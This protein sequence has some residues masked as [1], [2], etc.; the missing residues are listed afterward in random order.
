MGERVFLI[1]NI[2]YDFEFIEKLIK[3]IDSGSKFIP[4][5]YLNEFSIF[6]SMLISIDKEIINFNKK[7]H[8]KLLSL[9][10]SRSNE[11]LDDYCL[12]DKDEVSIDLTVEENLLDM[13]S[14]LDILKTNNKKRNLRTPLYD[15]S[16]L[17][18]LE[19]I[20]NFNELKIENKLNI[21]LEELNVLK[22]FKRHKPF[23][24]VELDKNIGSAIISNDL[25]F[26][27]GMKC[28][29]NSDT[30]EKIAY[31]PIGEIKNKIGRELFIIYENK[32]ISKKLY[33]KLFDDDF[34]Y[35]LGKFRYLP[36]IH[37]N[38]FSIRP[39]INYKDNPTSNLCILMDL[40]LRPFVYKMESYIK[41]SQNLIQKCEN[42][43]IE[44]S[45][46][47][48]YSCDFESLYTNID[49]NECLNL[50]S[51]FI[52]DKLCDE[53]IKIKGFHTILKLILENNYFSFE[54]NFYFHQKVGI[55]MGSRCGPSIANIFVYI[56][57]K[58][59]LNIYKP[60]LF[61]RFIDDIL[62]IVKERELVR[63]LQN[64]FGNLKLNICSSDIVNF[65]D[66]NISLNTMTNTLVFTPYYKPTNT[67]SYLLTNSNHPNFIF[68]NIPK[69]L[70]IRIRRIC[71]FFS[72][73]T[74]F[75]TILKDQLIKRG[76]DGKELEKVFRMV[77]KL[78]RKKL[79]CYKERESRT[80]ENIIIFKHEFDK[81]IKNF[82][83]IFRSSFD[84][85]FKN[86]DKLCNL[87]FLLVNKM[88]NNLK[89]ILIHDFEIPSIEKNYY[90]RC[91]D[92]KCNICMFSTREYFIKLKNISLPICVDSNCS[93]E[94]CVYIIKCNLCNAFY[95]GQTKSFKDRLR[96]HMT[97]IRHFKPFSGEYNSPVSIHFNLKN[98]NYLKQL[99][100]YII[101]KDILLLDNRLIIESFYI[102][103]FMKL[104][105]VVLNDFIPK[106]ETK[107]NFNPE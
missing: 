36:K 70:F 39:I 35:K 41:D 64:A 30:Y 79:L 13:E 48:I 61:S 43:K 24:V 101:Q 105:E 67:F 37:K 60:L 40:L 107:F 57:E 74:Y 14:I 1:G 100:F 52:K 96:N 49:Q 71:T 51:D 58:R 103:L 45:D 3:I 46:I 8:F 81:S 73:F 91:N 92:L 104:G 76:Y 94:N 83:E 27:L 97:Y 55:A 99:S 72:D 66:L 44:S 31:N 32:Y 63:S 17:F 42:L 98:H 62:I 28:L 50:I 90:K 75:S 102:N 33:K 65:L 5:Y 25:F 54:K 86:D 11:N 87:D 80:N 38:K 89:S 93:V 78:D 18:H 19:L 6:K 29:N 69:S 12:N 22:F 47:F 68:K 77:S 10:K 85:V 21:S 34:E 23:K 56:L 59:W 26:E 20:K 106:I 4:C 16:I 53:N 2:N 88:Q 15:K 84:K 95:V 7:L 82:N 9:N